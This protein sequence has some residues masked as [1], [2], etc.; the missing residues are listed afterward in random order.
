MRRL[1]SVF[2][3]TALVLALGVGCKEQGPMEKAGEAVD[4]A[5]E[6]MKDAGQGPM[7]RAGE[8]ADEAV[9]KTKE[10]VEGEK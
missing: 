2:S 6:D 9:E 4:E 3:V 10:A 1:I 5:V 8:D 7:E